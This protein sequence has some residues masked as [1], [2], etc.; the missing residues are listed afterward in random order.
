M[1]KQSSD[2]FGIYA[3][4][5]SAGDANNWLENLVY[6]N[7]QHSYLGLVNESSHRVIAE[8][9]LFCRTKNAEY[10]RTRLAS[11]YYSADYLACTLG[12]QKQFSNVAAKVGLGNYQLYMRPF[13]K[14]VDSPADEFPSRPITTGRTYAEAIEEWAQTCY[15][16]TLLSDAD[17]PFIP[18]GTA[19]HPAIN[20]RSGTKFGEERLDGTFEILDHEGRNAHSSV[21]AYSDLMPDYQRAVQTAAQEQDNS[22]AER[23]ASSSPADRIKISSTQF[24]RNLGKGFY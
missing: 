12:V 2:H 17:V 11:A 10:P 20:C 15:D 23:T 5:K 9:H 18:I 16:M 19:A 22:P 14:S 4:E 13:E 6:P 8:M 21:G 1:S 24:R 3:F 7:R